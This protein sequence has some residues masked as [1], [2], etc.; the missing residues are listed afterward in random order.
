MAKTAAVPF[1]PAFPSIPSLT[2]TSRLQLGL[3]PS[4][5]LIRYLKH[6]SVPYLRVC[7][8]YSFDLYRCEIIL[9]CTNTHG[10][11][12]SVW[13]LLLI[14]YSTLRACVFLVAQENICTL[15]RIPA[16]IVFRDSLRFSPS[17]CCSGRWM[18]NLWYIFQ[19]T[20]GILSHHKIALRKIVERM[21]FRS[22][23]E[24]CCTYVINLLK[25]SN[26]RRSSLNPH[27]ALVIAATNA[28]FL[29][30][31]TNLHSEYCDSRYKSSAAWG[32][33]AEGKLF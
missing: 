24:W 26:N 6:T 17:L 3:A 20:K 15:R 33:M 29:L 21:H 25:K 14:F 30:A 13:L 12:H 1:S 5:E 28:T 31:R 19:C 23:E 27:Q 2:C 22:G 32:T 16:T 9:N 4:T 8:I 10:H 7:C 18:N 11:L